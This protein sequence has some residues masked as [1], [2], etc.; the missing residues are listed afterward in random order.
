MILLDF[1]LDLILLLIWLAFDA[2]LIG[3]D[4]DS[5]RLEP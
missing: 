4:L 5:A 2:I 3:F 1:D